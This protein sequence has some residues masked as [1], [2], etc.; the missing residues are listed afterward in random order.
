MM[1][2]ILATAIKIHVLLLIFEEL[3]KELTYITSSPSYYYTGV[4]LKSGY[5]PYSH[6]RD[7]L[8]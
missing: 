8:H 6:K 2:E 5:N 7:V 1:D 3:I 4:N